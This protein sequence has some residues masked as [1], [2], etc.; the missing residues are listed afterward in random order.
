MARASRKK[1]LPISKPVAAATGKWN[2]SA[3]QW[4][5][6][7]TAYVSLNDEMRAEIAEIVDRYFQ[8]ERYGRNAGFEP[9]AVAWLQEMEKGALGFVSASG[10][11]GGGG[12]RH[13]AEWVLDEHLRCANIPPHR[14]L[15]RAMM[16]YA[17][18]AAATAQEITGED[19]PRLHEKDAWR[20]MIEGL[21]SFAF[22]NKLLTNINTNTHPRVSPFVAFVR[23][24]Q[25]TFGGFL[26]WHADNPTTLGEEIKRATREVRK[27]KNAKN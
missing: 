19:Q 1:R 12:A 7:E 8:D 14:F 25:A 17:R 23:E 2:P 15:M 9:D 22:D 24:L 21:W 18:A 26:A 20:V 3:E 16:E 5:K 27:F 13:H 4:A 11:A 10:R 6:I